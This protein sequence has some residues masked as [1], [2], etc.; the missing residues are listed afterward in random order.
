M[1]RMTLKPK[2]RTLRLFI[3]HH[4]HWKG[5]LDL[6]TKFH[7]RECGILWDNKLIGKVRQFI[8]V[9]HIMDLGPCRFQAVDTE[10][11]HVGPVVGYCN[12]IDAI[13]RLVN[14]VES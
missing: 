10:G 4:P 8:P 11:K 12:Q 7:S 14:E 13:E 3:M 5:R 6:A 9:G 2:D 1:E